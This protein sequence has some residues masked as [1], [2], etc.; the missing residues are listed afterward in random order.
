MPLKRCKFEG[1]DID[2]HAKDYCL[3]HYKRIWRNGHL[4]KLNDIPCDKSKWT[5]GNIGWL[6]GIIEGEGYINTTTKTSRIRVR[7]TD[8]DVILKI[9]DIAGCGYINGPYK[10]KNPNHKPSW[11][12]TVSKKLQVK[13]II[14]IIYPYLC[15]RRRKAIDNAIAKMFK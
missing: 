14:N 11:E 7:M 13:E 15:S 1:C 4:T 6:A 10:R 5:D 9:K 8:E 3:K 2:S 12:W